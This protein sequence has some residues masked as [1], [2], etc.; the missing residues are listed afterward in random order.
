MRHG[1]PNLPTALRA[2]P[3]QAELW[4][5]PGRWEGPEPARPPLSRLGGMGPLCLGRPPGGSASRSTDP[6][7]ASPS[8]DPQ[9][10]WSEASAPPVWDVSGQGGL[11]GCRRGLR[12]K[13]YFM[14]RWCLSR[15]WENFRR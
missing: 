2:E 7:L 6:S 5:G 13:E 10:L 11:V 12:F 3:G 1:E 8:S 15:N 14:E 4:R 9:C